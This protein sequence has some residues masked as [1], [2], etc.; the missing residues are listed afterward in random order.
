MGYFN[1]IGS[2]TN[3]NILKTEHFHLL[4]LICFLNFRN[5]WIK[6]NKRLVVKIYMMRMGRNC[7]HASLVPGSHL[8]LWPATSLWP[9]S[10][11][12]TCSLPSSS[13]VP[14]I[15][16]YLIILQRTSADRSRLYKFKSVIS[17]LYTLTGLRVLSP[18]TPS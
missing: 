4:N 14:I 8:P 2:S 16:V 17:L 1:K 13:N 5:N 11:W 10:Y 9:T 7:P 18:A 3:A 6:I 15:F 12:S